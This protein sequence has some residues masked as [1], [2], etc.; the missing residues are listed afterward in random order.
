MGVL[1]MILRIACWSCMAS[2]RIALHEDWIRGFLKSLGSCRSR[3]GFPLACQVSRLQD[4]V[5]RRLDSGFLKSLGSCRSRLGFPLASWRGSGGL[6]I[7]LPI[8]SSIRTAKG[9]ISRQTNTSGTN[10]ERFRHRLAD[11]NKD[12][13]FRVC[14][15]L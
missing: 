12:R 11:E 4:C 8:A 5:A 9:E 15:Q 3:L 14:Q 10:T 2:N 13:R 7:G 6:E 1:S